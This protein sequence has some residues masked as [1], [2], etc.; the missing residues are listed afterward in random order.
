M[1]GQVGIDSEG[2]LWCVVGSTDQTID[3]VVT[4]GSQRAVSSNG[5]WEYGNNLADTA[6]AFTENLV[7]ESKSDY[8]SKINETNESVA[9]INNNIQ[10][11][12]TRISTNESE[13]ISLKQYNTDND[14]K[15]S[16]IQTDI[17]SLQDKNTSQDQNIQQIQEDISSSISEVNQNIQQNRTEIESDY[18]SKISTL[19]SQVTT[20]QNNIDSIATKIEQVNQDIQDSQNAIFQNAQSIQTLQDRCTTIESNVQTNKTNITSLT[21]RV[22]SNESNIQ[23]QISR[24]NN[25][26]TSST[27][28]ATDIK[29]LQDQTYGKFFNTEEELLQWVSIQDNIKNLQVGAGLYLYG[30]NSLYYIWNG[31]ALLKFQ[32]IDVPT[33]GYMTKN[34]PSGSGT[35]SMNNCQSGSN[36]AAF[37]VDNTADGECS[38][39]SGTGMEIGENYAFGIGRYNQQTVDGE[40]FTVG[41]GESDSSRKSAM[42]IFETGDQSLYGD[43][44]I[45]SSQMSASG[46]PFVAKCKTEYHFKNIPSNVR[47]QIDYDLFYSKISENED[48]MYSITRSSDQWILDDYKLR[49]SFS[50]LSDVGITFSYTD[51][52]SGTPQF[53]FDSSDYITVYAPPQVEISLRNFY[54]AFSSMNLYVDEDGDVCQYEL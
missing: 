47:L 4:S 20:N 50:N 34:N 52:T 25:L 2:R 10:S 24:I 53:Q 40:I 9:Q 46:K 36:S 38:L 22:T 15:I 42:R 49:T 7:N 26:S 8:T 31:T 13:I 23:T 1:T 6:R 32:H 33:E 44:Q 37:G 3:Q 16:K 12:T 28:Y 14:S 41:I 11:L 51:E 27:Q 29:T 54:S 5:V 35:I 21:S 45:Y 39:I 19:Q 17:T 48:S 43:I 18:N 30:S